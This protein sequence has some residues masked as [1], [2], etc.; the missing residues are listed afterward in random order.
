VIK[1]YGKNSLVKSRLNVCKEL[2][3]II[4]ELLALAGKS[5]IPDIQDGVKL[6]W[7]R[8]RS[9]SPKV[10]AAFLPKRIQRSAEAGAA[11][12]LSRFVAGE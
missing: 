1:K 5:N 9:K 8:E 7:I 11:S 10:S 3:S 6:P 12:C 2:A 4:D